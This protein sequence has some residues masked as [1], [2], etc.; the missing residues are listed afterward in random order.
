MAVQTGEECSAVAE[1][2]PN[3]FRTVTIYIV[4][5]RLSN[6]K[7]K[8]RAMIAIRYWIV[9]TT[10]FTSC[11]LAVA[12]DIPTGKPQIQ[13]SN[14]RIEFDNHLRSRV[15]ARF[16]NKE[17]VMGPFTASETVTTVDKPQA[18]FLLT[19]QKQERT[20]DAF[21]ED[22][23]LTV[24]GRAGTLMK[25]VTVTIYDD[26]PAMAFFDV[27]YTNTGKSKLT[28]KSWT[29]NAYIVSAESGG[30]S[31]AFWSY[32]SGSYEK[33]PNWV[34]PLRTKFQQENYQGMNASDYGGGTP[35][36]DVWRRDVGIAV[37]HVELRPKLV[38]LP[39]SMPD[40]AHAKIA[41]RFTKARSLGPGESFHTFRTFV[42]VHRGDY[43]RTLIDYRRFMMKQGFQ[44]ATAPNEAF[45][46]IWCAWGYGRK[47]QPQQVYDSLPTVKRL[48]FT[49][50]TLDDGW[51]N[52]VGDW[53]LDLKKFPHGDADMKALVDRIHQEGFKAQLWWSPLSAVPTSE[54][55]REHP[56]YELLNRDG[57]KRKVSWWNSYYLCPA[58][59]R[60][61]EHHRALVKKILVDWGFDGL[62]L[63][64]QDMNGVPAC[65]NP[66]HHHARPEE[67]VEALPDFFKAIY[68]TAQSV[69]P[70]T[71]VEFCPCGT[72]YSFFTMPHFNMS[73]ASDPE[74]SFQVR[75]KGKTL[76]ALMGDDVPFFGDHVELSDGG[77]D[78]ASTVG[79]G[80]VVGTQFVLPSL[81]TKH[82]KSDLTPAREKD[83]EKWLRI[84]REKMLSRGEYLG[85]LYDI[86]FDVP[87]T[88]AIR[89]GQTMYYA[90]FAKQWRGTVELRGLEDRNYSVSDYASGKDFGTVSG[91]NAQ[92]PVEFA[93]HL[94]LEA[95]PQ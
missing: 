87:E 49:W 13:G 85:Q 2:P 76:K 1:Q 55:L 44:M 41:V 53:Q 26:F 16:G 14:L 19:S 38:S 60:V 3:D 20:K 86:G 35:I 46:A 36:V 93:G 94:L 71:L 48:G 32:Q 63:D 17:T 84:Y 37:G 30:S 33:R 43:F 10:V 40:A 79:V 74:S 83:F 70:G 95:R 52:N 90:F 68:E 58:D 5:C 81:V 77:N 65:Y 59:Q 78:F 22:T 9:L 51:Q 25:K 27:Q 62:K 29:D 75:S 92:L 73:V 50:V 4:L 91:H 6:T 28:I 64:G 34:L 12:A 15:V 23:Q 66:A 56:E 82:G 21:G 89:K 57:S 61:V 7:R 42:A 45:G 67:S 80:G 69:K 18:V 88:H 54:L 31:P 72:A 11:S 24:E 8:R 47:V 39:V